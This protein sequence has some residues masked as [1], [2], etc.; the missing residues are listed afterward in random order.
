[1]SFGIFPS[2]RPWRL[3]HSSF[4]PNILRDVFSKARYRR[5]ISNY[6]LSVHVWNQKDSN[7]A[8]PMTQRISQ[9]IDAALVLRHRVSSSSNSSWHWMVEQ[10]DSMLQYLTLQYRSLRM[11]VP[12][13][14]C[15]ITPMEGSLSLV[16]QQLQSFQ[17]LWDQLVA[18]ASLATASSSATTQSWKETAKGRNT[19]FMVRRALLNDEPVPLDQ[20]DED[21]DTA[22][23]DDV[24]DVAI[25]GA[26]LG[27][28]CAGAILNTIYG[29]KVAIYESHYLPGGCAHAFERSVQNHHSPSTTFTFDSGPT[30]L[31]GCSAAPY[32]ALR[33]VLN[34]VQQNVTWI[35]YDGWGM[36]EQY[37]RWNETTIPSTPPQEWRVT[38][39]P[40]EFFDGPLRRFGGIDAVQEFRTLQTLTKSLTVGASIPA[41]AM[42]AGSSA[43]VPLLLR[44]FST[45]LSLIQQGDVVT[46][47]FAPY[48][49]GP[50]H[51]VRSPWLR[52]WL[53]ALAF[54]LSGLPASRT[55]AAAMAFILQDMHR[56]GATLDYPVGGIGEVVQALVRAVQQG[57]NGSKVYLRQHVQSIDGNAD[58]TKVTGVT[59]RKQNRRIRAREGVICNAPIWSLRDLVPDERLRNQLNLGLPLIDPQPKAPVAWNTTLD[60]SSIHEQRHAAVKASSESSGFLSQ[61]ESVEMTA[62]F[63]HLHLALNATG[64]NLSAL[65]A[66]YTVMD[67]SLQG[68]E[69]VVINGVKDGPC[70][71][72]NMIA[73]SNPCV[74]DRNLAPEG[75]NVMHAYGAGNEPYELWEDVERNTPEYVARKERRAEPLWRAVECIIPDA[76]DRA[77]L[78]LIGTPQ[79]HERFLRRPRG[80]YGSVTEDYLRDGAT[81]VSNFVLASDSVFPGIGVPAVAI[82]GASAANSL[83]PVLEHLRALDR[84]QR[85]GRL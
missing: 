5:R 54:S 34:A 53:D 62:S 14:Q 6:R 65:E 64:L 18:P 7:E 49:D 84:L 9:L 26:G 69:S 83:V 81:P 15:T 51:T 79:T 73:V 3:A 2:A 41:M 42:R 10:L 17:E 76:R 25:V 75:Y 28:L 23:D 52:N 68:D 24:V 36:V 47:T 32:N 35:P 59:L 33:Q 70:G 58:G 85:D 11:D 1:L 57:P 22:V 12:P 72:G 46:G 56:Q 55:A 77:V 74:L 63:I 30:I 16:A 66:H 43:V 20:D 8:V 67:R 50:I 29:K 71:L 19:D 80:T 48:M 38:L 61:L 60:G 4:D 44:H 39:G 45:L 78:S 21:D 40:T 13:L 37:N 82:A 31:L 27:G